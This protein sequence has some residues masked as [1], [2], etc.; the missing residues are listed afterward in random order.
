MIFLYVSIYFFVFDLSLASN[1]HDYNNYRSTRATNYFVCIF[2][3]I[4]IDF[5]R[6]EWACIVYYI[7][8]YYIYI[9]IYIYILEYI[10]ERYAKGFA[11]G[12]KWRVYI[13]TYTYIHTTV[14]DHPTQDRHHRRLIRERVE[15]LYCFRSSSQYLFY[16]PLDITPCRRVSE[17]MSTRETGRKENEKKNR[18]N[19]LYTYIDRVTSL[20]FP[21]LLPIRCQWFYTP[22]RPYKRVKKRII[23]SSACYII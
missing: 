10:Q 22:H 19:I 7:V 1:N 5:G 21:L 14:V 17:G 13:C 15:L 12:N 20:S 6:F 4:V 16:I 9:C 8:L 11:T 23:L 2:V 18:E 3:F